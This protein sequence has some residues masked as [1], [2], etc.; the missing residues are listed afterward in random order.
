[1][2]LDGYEVRQIKLPDQGDTDPHPRLLF[3]K[4][5]IHAGEG[6]TAWLPQGWTKIRIEVSWRTTGAASWY[7]PD[8]PDI[9]PVGLF[10]R[11]DDE[12]G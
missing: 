5:G 4:W 10:C 2:T 3:G 11:V 9:C 12:R 7:I 8:Y 1:M 6:F